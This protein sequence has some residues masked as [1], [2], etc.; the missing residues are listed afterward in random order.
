MPEALGASVHISGVSGRGSHF[1]TALPVN[2]SVMLEAA[3]S[4]RSLIILGKTESVAAV[5]PRT[6]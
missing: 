5:A 1:S 6:S 3:V 4:W 2:V